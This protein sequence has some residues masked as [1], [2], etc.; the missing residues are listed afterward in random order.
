M[1]RALFVALA[2]L[3]VPVAVSA[4]PVC[5]NQ[6][7]GPLIDAARLGIWLLLAVVGAVQIAF[8]AF[9]LHLRRQARRHADSALDAEWSELQQQ[10]DRQGRI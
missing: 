6:T 3:L 5:F 7:E 8:A 4:C 2:L 1:S 9:F 10:W